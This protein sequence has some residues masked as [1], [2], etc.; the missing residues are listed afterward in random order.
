MNDE[1]GA[2][3]GKL[4][5]GSLFSRLLI[6]KKEPLRLIAV[7]R[8]HVAGDRTRGDALLAGRFELGAEAIDL[9]DFD[10]AAVGAGSGMAA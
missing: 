7:P 6:A 3:I 1:A 8:D 10:F 4:A 2:V 9:T 5:R